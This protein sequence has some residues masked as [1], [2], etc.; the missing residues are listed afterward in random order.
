MGK[1]VFAGCDAIE[2]VVADDKRTLSRSRLMLLGVPSEA[3][4][5]SH[6][7]LGE[8]LLY[9]ELADPETT[10]DRKR[11]IEASLKK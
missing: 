6:R 3:H 4:V 5:L 9:A 7:E 2:T 8:A 1:G 10:A 11:E